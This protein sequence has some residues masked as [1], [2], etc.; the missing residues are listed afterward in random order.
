MLSI[1]KHVKEFL[2][3][4][5]KDDRELLL[6]KIWCGKFLSLSHLTAYLSAREEVKC[7]SLMSFSFLK[8]T[9]KLISFLNSL[10]PHC[11]IFYYHRFNIMRTPARICCYVTSNPCVEMLTLNSRH[12]STSDSL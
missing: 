7:I 2:S 4:L 1:Q 3:I 12:I 6:L 9:G 10:V 8:C 5:H 11:V